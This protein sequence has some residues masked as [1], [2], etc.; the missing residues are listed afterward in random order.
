MLSKFK[1][2]LTPPKAK[3]PPKPEKP[4]S[5][6]SVS[7]GKHAQY[8]QQWERLQQLYQTFEANPWDDSIEKS[9]Q[10]LLD[11]LQKYTISDH[12]AATVS[13]EDVQKYKEYALK[14]F[15]SMGTI[16][17]SRVQSLLD[18]SHEEMHKII[19]ECLFLCDINPANAPPFELSDSQ[20][21]DAQGNPILEKNVYPIF[22]E[23]ALA[24]VAGVE[25]FL[26]PAMLD[27]DAAQHIQGMKSFLQSEYP[28]FA[29]QARTQTAPMIQ[30]MTSIGSLGGLSHKPDS[31]IDL[32]I[33]FNTNP[34]YEHRWN[35]ADF[36][37]AL[38]NF[39]L[40][41]LQH[42]FLEKNLPNAQ[43]KALKEKVVNQLK[44]QY[45]QNLHEAE[46]RIITQILPSTY[47][48]ILEEET[49]A[50][51]NKLELRQQSLLIQR[52][53]VK[54]L[55][56]LPCVGIF[57][58]DLK[59]CF[60]LLKSIRLE[61][62]HGICFPYSTQTLTSKKVENWFSVFY[63]DHYLGKKGAQKMLQQHSQKKGMRPENLDGNTQMRLIL[64]KI[65]QSKHRFSIIESFLN[66]FAEKISFEQKD[67]L[68]EI[69]R[70]LHKKF[71][72]QNLHLKEKIEA[73]LQH[74]L[75]QSFRSQMIQLIDF[76]SDWEATQFEAQSESA[77]HHKV[78][79]LQAY[80]TRKYPNTELYLFLN[81]LRNQRLGKHTPFL[82]SPEGSMAYSLMLNDSLLNPAVIL[83]GTSPMPF[84]IPHDLKVM[85]ST[86]I[87]TSDQWNLTQSQ[88]KN[89]ETFRFQQLCDW[90]ASVIPRE[91]LWA[92]ALPIYL[93]ESEKVS[94]R[95]LPKALLNCWWLEMLCCLEKQ[96]QPTSLTQLL[97]NPNQRHFLKYEI[98][99]LMVSKI[100]KIEAGYP[101]LM[102]DPWW[103][104]FTEMLVRFQ[105]ETLR[106]QMV[107]CFAQHIRLTDIVDFNNEGKPI[108]LDKDVS[109]RTKALV[110]F[111]NL[112]FPEQEDR[113]FLIKFAQGRDDVCHQKENELKQAFLDSMRRT[114]KKLLAIGNQ[115]AA[116]RILPYLKKTNKG[117]ALKGMEATVHQVLK[118]VNRYVI[119]AD[120]TLLEKAKRQES[121]NAM[122]QKQLELLKKDRQQLRK[123]LEDMAKGEA[124]GQITFS[125]PKLEKYI[126]DARIKLAGDPL[127]NVLFKHHFERNF[128]RL[129][130]QIPLPISKSLSIPRKKIMLKF[131]VDEENWQFNS[132]LS[133]RDS[134]GSGGE[135]KMEMFSAPLVEGLARCVFSGYVGFT[136]KEL[137]SFEKPAVRHPSPV[138]R[139][140]ITHQDIQDL[141]FAIKDFFQPYRVRPQELLENIHYITQIFM[142]GN[143]SRFGTISLIV[144]DNFGNHFVVN[145]NLAKIKVKL[146]TP[147]SQEEKTF[148]QFFLQLHSKT[149]RE[150]F[151]K[152]IHQ[153][154]IPLNPDH[155]PQFKIWINGGNFE[156][157]VAPKFSRIYLNGIAETLWP[158]AS[159]GTPQMLH[160]QKLE[161]SFDQMGKIVIQ[162][163]QRIEAEKQALIEKA[164]QKNTLRARAYMNR[165]RDAMGL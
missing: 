8:E 20:G 130:F 74:S 41:N 145:Y 49:W 63:V 128:S 90:G 86:G 163:H 53:F 91:K 71:D 39:L 9:L 18:L 131:D 149:S 19:Y 152:S 125:I 29:S 16:N 126:L 3:P 27:G 105:N 48:K 143:V 104:K 60:P 154:S 34:I 98:K 56:K 96:P 140:P 65:S 77:L 14:E 137:T 161:H 162:R 45:G 112:F 110:A 64:K 25:R 75:H 35:D 15:E 47:Q 147:L 132:I 73:D 38:W 115:K 122:E 72:P 82:V 31:D 141:A 30:A 24:G 83:A 22:A 78:Q 102:Q 87:L 4:P 116:K 93:R 159:I 54:D 66:T 114:E 84:E 12:L 80:L 138:A 155:K 76:Y 51:F 13:Q 26:P 133:K 52:Q 23:N 67:R 89:S 134:R 79:M 21:Y 124:I 62:L 37:I 40:Q 100:Q 118:E 142:V 85:L 46:T 148:E 33:I 121:L 160:S 17:R 7:V 135:S 55:V 127:E 61:K 68:I 146:A 2:F 59:K 129:P 58:A 165:K 150:A 42:S 158:A 57:F 139:N 69:T 81:I 50:V 28:A 151:Q 103:I 95:N 157:K 44:A 88:D 36:F 136:A 97:W 113:I 101:L 92:H 94:H 153:L 120:E 109:W 119:I 5:E 43:R 6:K 32:Q 111:Y 107:F 117:K 144:R 10:N 11:S 156:L 164:N 123:V 70:L 99:N 1:N 108:W 106:Q